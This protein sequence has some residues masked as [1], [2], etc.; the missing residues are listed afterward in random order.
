MA[1]ADPAGP[2]PTTT[3]LFPLYFGSFAASRVESVFRLT[4]T[5]S[6]AQVE[7]Y[8]VGVGLLVAMRSVLSDPN[9]ERSDGEPEKALCLL[10][11][12]A[13]AALGRI[14]DA[15]PCCKETAILPLVWS[16]ED[17]SNDSVTAAT[18]QLKQPT[19]TVYFGRPSDAGCHV[20]LML[21]ESN[22]CKN[23]HCGNTPVADTRNCKERLRTSLATLCKL[24]DNQETFA[25]LSLSSIA[26][27]CIRA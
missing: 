17:L 9:S 13:G 6:S 22:F 10:G 21:S 8:V 27:Q 4:S 23:E 2:A 3:A 5:G 14:F 11:L 20:L 7:A 26:F 1:A 19:G 15:M 16:N 25:L 12:K 24:R 18:V